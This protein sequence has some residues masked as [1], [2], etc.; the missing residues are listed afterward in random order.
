[1]ASYKFIAA[2][3]ILHDILFQIDIANQSLQKKNLDMVAAVEHINQTRKFLSKWRNDG[4]VE[5]KL[6]DAQEICENM[7]ILPLF[8]SEHRPTRLCKVPQRNDNEAA[9]FPTWNNL[10][11]SWLII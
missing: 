3:V 2:L 6:V 8:A 5:G 7:G 11:A 10:G 4:E 9:F 1:M